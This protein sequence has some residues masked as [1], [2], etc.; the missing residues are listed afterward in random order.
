[1]SAPS[2]PSESELEILPIISRCAI[3]SIVCKSINKNLL[4]DH[5]PKSRSSHSSQCYCLEAHQQ[6]PVQLVKKGK[7]YV[8]I[9]EERVPLRTGSK[10]RL[11]NLTILTRMLPCEQ[12]HHLTPLISYICGHLYSHGATFKGA[13]SILSAPHQQKF[14][15]MQA[16]TD[17][18]NIHEGMGVACETKGKH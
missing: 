14:Q 3:I 7:L 6:P 2:P 18:S 12:A 11:Q 17:V 16:Q 10:S 4:A 13:E 8:S 1:M 9:H 5:C 15:L